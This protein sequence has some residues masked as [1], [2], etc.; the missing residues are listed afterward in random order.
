MR[1]KECDA[2]PNLQYPI[3]FPLSLQFLYHIKKVHFLEN[4]IH[5]EACLLQ[6]KTSPIQSLINTPQ[7]L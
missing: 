2:R 3:I 4:S 6:N 1:S 5:A 7:T